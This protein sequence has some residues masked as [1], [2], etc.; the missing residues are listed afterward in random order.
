MLLFVQPSLFF[1]LPGN[2]PPPPNPPQTSAIQANPVQPLP[3]GTV[4]YRNV[5]NQTRSQ[6]CTSPQLP[7]EPL[8]PRAS[9]WTIVVNIPT[10]L[11]MGEPSSS[12]VKHTYTLYLNGTFSAKDDHGNSFAV[13]PLLG[14]PSGM[15]STSLRANSTY[16][17]QNYLVAPGGQTIANVTVAYAIRHQF[18][19]PAGLRMEIKGNANW[20]GGA[21]AAATTTTHGALSLR[22]DRVPISARGDR[23]WFGN[24]SGVWLGFDWS[25][26]DGPLF[27]P[28]FNLARAQLTYQV[29]GSF[30]IDPVTV[31]TTSQPY[32]TE[33]SGQ[34]SVVY[35]NGYYWVF[36]FCKGQFYV[37]V[38]Y[39]SSPDSATWSA[40]TRIT[41]LDFLGGDGLDVAVKPGTNA[42]ALVFWMY[43]QV[44]F[45][46]L[47][48]GSDGVLRVGTP[49]SLFHGD[50]PS[51]GCQ[52][53][54]PLRPTV[55]WSSG[56]RWVVTATWNGCTDYGGR[57]RCIG[58]FLYEAY[59][60]NP[61]GS[62]VWTVYR[63]NPTD[64]SNTLYAEVLQNEGVV[65]S[66][67]GTLYYEDG[68]GAPLTLTDWGNTVL[69]GNRFASALLSNGTVAV[70]AISYPSYILYYVKSSNWASRLTI[71]SSSPSSPS[72]TVSMTTDGARA[73][74]AYLPSPTS[75]S[76]ATLSSSGPTTITGVASGE[77][78]SIAYL[79]M[80]Q[81]TSPF[82]LFSWMSGSSS[83]YSVR[84]ASVPATVPTAATS[85]NSWSRPGL[86]PYEGY[87][88]NFMEYVSPGNG[89]LSVGQ[90]TL[91]LPGRGGLYLEISLVYSQ[92]YAFRSSSSPYQYDNFTLSNLGDGW[93]LSLPWLGTNYLHL[94]DG[95]AYPYEWSGSTFTYHRTVDFQLVQNS[96]GG[97]SGTYTLYD[98]S[99]TTYQFNSNKQLTSITDQTGNN[100]IT[101]SYGAEGYISQITD[102][103][104][105]VVSFSYNSNKQ[106]ASISSG[107]RAW[108]LA[109]SGN[110]LV[111]VTDPI[112]RA[113]TYEY[114]TGNLWLVSGVLYSTGGKTTYSYGSAPVGTEAKT[115]YVTSRNVYS[116][117]TQLSQ[118]DS[119]SYNILNGNAVWSNSTMSDGAS[120]QAYQDYNFQN[121]KNL[122]R[123]YDKTSSGSVTKIAESDYDTAGRVNETKLLSPSNALLSYS[124]RSYDDWGNVKY[125]KD[126]VGHET[127]LSYANTDSSDTFGTS[128]C[129]PSFFSQTISANIHDAIVGTC[130]YQSGVGTAQE[131]A[132]YK[133]DPRG[134]LLEQKVLHDGGW[135]YTDYTHDKY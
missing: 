88:Q 98:K 42:G 113:T 100:T 62:G 107:G 1:P 91:A 9:N 61:D 35:N 93:S 63:L 18:C 29:N 67:A 17:E 133:Y 70:A 129:T 109:Y 111:S 115:Y 128:G 65:V 40:P 54:S 6:H 52:G 75:V 46:G 131:Q 120:I 90:G 74:V 71:A 60:S 96:G 47:T 87:F 94:A 11:F 73:F 14:L 83:P 114:H 41:S 23:A 122:M 25:D 30:T 31:A 123:V 12:Y 125:S 69:N 44:E 34:H 64:A 97:S 108:T 51:T 24:S 84:L 86:S 130:S 3:P 15:M 118:S 58:M 50:C 135:L 27:H 72:V 124:V 49:Y 127:W 77:L 56:G 79:S 26:S 99:G 21:A 5:W 103:V 132:Y 16:A 36:F 95:Q 104:G 32:P 28:T 82:L 57:W 38:C 4:T 76:F 43:I 119:I 20:G 81:S 68:L 59:D 7:R 106:L 22:F 48:F 112:G 53:W 19:E 102:A 101:F 110:N 45:I 116:S 78:N 105:R 2:A 85:Q 55:V 89:L 8:S 92:P 121:S 13:R 37:D 134:N 33:E 117:P 126:S 39:A 66:V 80:A 10:L